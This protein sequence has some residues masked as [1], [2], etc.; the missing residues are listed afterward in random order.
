MRKKPDRFM[1]MSMVADA[2]ESFDKDAVDE[3]ST[4]WSTPRWRKRLVK[5]KFRA[6]IFK[7]ILISDDSDT[8]DEDEEDKNQID[9]KQVK[10]QVVIEEN[11]DV[12]ESNE[13]MKFVRV[14]DNVIRFVWTEVIHD[15]NA[16]SD[17]TTLLPPPP[18]GEVYLR[19]TSRRK[20][21][22]FKIKT[23]A[24]TRYSTR[25]TYFTFFLLDHRL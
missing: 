3:D 1:L 25:P 15:S 11:K 5:Y 24:P 20:R 19:N 14:D 12:K 6:N 18:F 23:T 22:I 2:E 17:N 4:L 8:S 13:V 21:A 10:I 9:E 7:R 16:I